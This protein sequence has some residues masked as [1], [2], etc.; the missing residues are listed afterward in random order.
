LYVGDRFVSR[1]RS[2]RLRRRYLGR[3]GS[4][5]S[6]PGATLS[7]RRTTSAVPRRVRP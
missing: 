7:T 4:A 3:L 5:R 1:S 2:C 6:G